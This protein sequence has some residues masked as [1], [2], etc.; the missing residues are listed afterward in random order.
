MKLQSFRIRDYKA[1]LDSGECD[2]S[3]E[4]ITILAGQNE[5]GKTSI[6]E[7]LRDFDY[8]D[9]INSEAQPD[10]NED[11]EPT[12]DCTF[13]LDKEDLESLTDDD[14]GPY[15]LSKPVRDALLKRGKVTLRKANSDVY[16]IVDQEILDVLEKA[17][18]LQAPAAE[19]AAATEEDPDANEQKPAEPRD[20]KKELTIALVRRSPYMI[21]FD[22]FDGRLPRKKYLSE[23]DDKTTAGYQAVQ[24]FIKLAGIDVKRLSAAADPKQLSN[25]L[26]SKSAKVTGDFLN[27]WSQ[28]YDGENQV[29]I[30][31]EL[32]RDDKGP[33][34]NFYVKDKR[35]RKYPEQRS[36]GFLWFLSFY[37]RL[38]AESLDKEDV[39]AVILIDEP[40]SYLHPRA[41]KDI[42]KI[43]KEKI[44]KVKNQVIFST[45]S[46]DLI[47]PERINR[48]RIVLNRKGKGTKIHKLTD[49]TARENGTTEFADALSPIIAA[50][51]K[52]LGKD[53][54]IVGK[55]NVLVEGISDYYYLTTLREKAAY[56]IPTDIRIIPMT[57][58]L[59]ISHMVSIMIG[60]GLEYVVVM[61]RD[62]QSN[63][64]HKKLVEE[65]D[66]PA[67][68][69]HRI[70]GGKAIE[71]LFSEADFKKFILGD[72]KATLPAGKHKSDFVRDQKVILSRQFCERYK[73]STLALDPTTKDNF[74]RI[75]HFIKEA[76]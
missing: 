61:D 13:S 73:D 71:D 38:N 1:I 76:F 52:D 31:T 11:A 46:S 40:G 25:Y 69:I 21:Y 9:T 60:W 55:K 28:K 5:S 36:K 34:L 41:Q 2:P 75:T 42:L 33:F 58:A 14:D 19:P 50:I 7:A 17:P 43:L 23:V 8:S 10:D 44:V 12:I 20:L 66:V 54:S 6:L 39:G 72:E 4:N 47:D 27:Y 30:I 29:E 45:H 56:K 74:A 51:G 59:S 64:E 24:D 3:Q 63:A 65:L 16:S 26:E 35:L 15:E 70:D 32:N 22:S 53:F 18:P 37:L 48:V 67:A 68:K 62:E 57:G 49:T